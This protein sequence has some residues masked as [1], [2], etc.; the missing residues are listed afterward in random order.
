LAIIIP[1]YVH[2]NPHIAKQLHPPLSRT[3]AK[4]YPESEHLSKNL[5]FLG[6]IIAITFTKPLGLSLTNFITIP[7][8][9]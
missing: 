9:D 6:S 5:V 2:S 4:N 1:F 3:F 8:I 7:E